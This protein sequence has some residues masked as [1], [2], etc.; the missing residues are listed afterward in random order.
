MPAPDEK[1]PQPQDHLEEKGALLDAATQIV[2][3][4][5]AGVA[6]AYATNKLNGSKQPK[7]PPKRED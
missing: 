6:G 1:R 3:S 2:S 4:G 5:V 7:Q